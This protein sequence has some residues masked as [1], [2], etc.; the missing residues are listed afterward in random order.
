M[1]IW[2]AMFIAGFSFAFAPN[3]PAME[4]KPDPDTEL[5]PWSDQPLDWDDFRGPPQRRSVMVAESFTQLSYSWSCEDDSAQFQV[6]AHFNPRKSWVRGEPTGK[7][8]EHEQ[9]H[10]DITEL[11]ARKLRR[12]FSNLEMPCTYSREAISAHYQ[13]VLDRWRKTQK[14]Y[15]RETNHSLIRSEQKKWETWVKDELAQLDAYASNK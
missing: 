3:L 15:D 13:E 5:I 4:P 12:D 6:N 2:G 9:L 8:L 7:L 14:R 11:F 1:L 10:F